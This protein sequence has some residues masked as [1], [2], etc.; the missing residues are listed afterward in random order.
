MM[1]TSARGGGKVVRYYRITHTH[2]PIRAT[3]SDTAHDPLCAALNTRPVASI[4]CL[5]SAMPVTINRYRHTCARLLCTTLCRYIVEAHAM[6]LT[7][8]SSWVINGARVLLARLRNRCQIESRSSLRERARRATIAA[9]GQQ[10]DCKQPHAWQKRNR[11]APKPNR[12]QL[13]KGRQIVHRCCWTGS[14]HAKGAIA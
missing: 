3:R 4:V 10:R 14:I 8:H 11:R 5:S 2:E 6:V 1:Y 13:A 12:T 7:A 9:N